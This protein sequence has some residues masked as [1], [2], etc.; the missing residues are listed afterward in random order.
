PETLTSRSPVVAHPSRL[1]LWLVGFVLLALGA[2]AYWYWGQKAEPAPIG[3]QS[4][5]ARFGMGN[6][7]IPV[8]L[9]PVRT[10]TVNVQ[11][12]ALGTV[13]PLNTVTLRSRLDG[14]LVRVLF[15]EGQRVRQGDLLAEIDSRPY[16]VA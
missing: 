9:A 14:E 12:R 8:R 1:R 6:Q 15:T 11:I 3:P 2:A 16:Q 4:F 10:D 7:P 13:T 5:R